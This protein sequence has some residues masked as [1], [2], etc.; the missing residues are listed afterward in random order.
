MGGLKIQGPLYRQNQKPLNIPYLRIA[1]K[2]KHNQNFKRVAI[3]LDQI[4]KEREQQ[5]AL[6]T[7]LTRRREQ[8]ERDLKLVNRKLSKGE[9]S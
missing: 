8:G 1:N 9:E 7:E 4:P 6:R 5:K 2:L 3:S